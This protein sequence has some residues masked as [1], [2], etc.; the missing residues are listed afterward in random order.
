MDVVESVVEN[1]LLKEK[2]PVF[3][4]ILLHKLLYLLSFLVGDPSGVRT[5]VFAVRGRCPSPLDD[6]TN[7]LRSQDSNLENLV[8]SQA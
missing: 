8:Q 5:R 7:W 1:F 6:G 2:N 4:R 3:H